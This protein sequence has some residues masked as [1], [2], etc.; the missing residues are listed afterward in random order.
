MLPV[1]Y[2]DRAHLLQSIFY[3]ARRYDMAKSGAIKM[4][5]KL[6]RSCRLR[7][8]LTRE[9]LFSILRLYHQSQRWRMATTDD[10]DHP[11]NKRVRSVGE[12]LS[13]NCAWAFC[14]WRRSP[15]AHDQPGQRHIIPQVILSVKP[16]SASIKAFSAPRS[17]SQ[18][19]D[20]TPLANL[21]RPKRRVSALGPGGCR[22][23]ERQWRSATFMKALRRICPIETRKA[24][25]SV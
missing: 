20:Q 23:R 8:H 4:N 3:D 17:L 7:P 24:R 5:K 16:I 25:T 6:A 9:D 2:P 21:R 19:M 14:G 13:R 18:F 10:I 11:E 15:R 1:P 22:D 12:L